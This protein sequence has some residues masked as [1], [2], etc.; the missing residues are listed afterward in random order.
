MISTS[1]S[2]NKASIAKAKVFDDSTKN[3]MMLDLFD[4]YNFDEITGVIDQPLADYV[5]IKDDWGS[6]NLYTSGGPVLRSEDDCIS[7]KCLDFINDSATNLNRIFRSDSIAFSSNFT[8]S[9]W[10]NKRGGCRYN[11]GIYQ[12]YDNTGFMEMHSVDN[13]NTLI[14]QGVSAN[15]F[16][17]YLFF[18]DSTSKQLQLTMDKNILNSWHLITF[19]YSDST[20]YFKAYLDGN[21]FYNNTVELLKN[22]KTSNNAKINIG[23]YTTYWAKGKVDEFRIYNTALSDAQIKQNYIAGLNSMLA[24]GNI[25]KEEYN[26][27]IS[28]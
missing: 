3:S 18:T 16:I 14:Y 21:I 15:G 7:G 27:C 4:E 25:S 13:G 23:K 24:N 10:I 5:L 2:I 1:S 8:I 17:I 6:A 20:K 22:I 11:G 19:S 9:Y 26:E 28:L 12:N